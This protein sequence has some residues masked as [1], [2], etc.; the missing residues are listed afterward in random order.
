MIKKHQIV[1]PI[2]PHLE[3]YKMGINMI[4]S[5]SH[6]ISGFISGIFLIIFLVVIS[7]NHIETICYNIYY[8]YIYLYQI[9]VFSLV[10]FILVTLYHTGITLIKYTYEEKISLFKGSFDKITFNVLSLII[11]YSLI[12]LYLLV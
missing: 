3:I 11:F 7:L 2:T 8:L 6:R 12:T 1:R 9:L 5:I 4:I 10:I